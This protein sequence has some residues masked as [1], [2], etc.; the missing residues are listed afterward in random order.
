MEGKGGGLSLGAWSICILLGARFG[1]RGL[2]PTSEGLA[3]DFIS[4]EFKCYPNIEIILNMGKPLD[5][6]IH[7]GVYFSE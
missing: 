5:L 1:D 7:S 4:V 2:V 6:D 3:T